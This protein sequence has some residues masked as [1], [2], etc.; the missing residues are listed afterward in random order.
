MAPYELFAS[1]QTVRTHA[2]AGLDGKTVGS[3]TLF[4][5]QISAI[6]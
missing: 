3:F 2:D 5:F 4:A 1:E 6:S